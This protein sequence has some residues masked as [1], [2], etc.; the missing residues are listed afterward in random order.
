MSKYLATITWQRGADEPFTDNAYSRHHLWEF[1]GGL[2][3][4]ASASPDIVPS[5]A[6]C[7]WRLK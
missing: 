2:T 4:P 1:D 3:V 5:L 7:I 6:V